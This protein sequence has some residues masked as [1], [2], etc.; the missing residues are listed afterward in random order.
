[1]MTRTSPETRLCGHFV[2]TEVDVC[3]ARKPP[4]ARACGGKFIGSDQIGPRWGL[5]GVT[6]VG[7]GASAAAGPVRGALPP[8][9]SPLVGPPHPEL[10]RWGFCT[11]LRLPRRGTPQPESGC[12]GLGRD[13]GVPAPRLRVARRRPGDCA[14]PRNTADRG[15][16][17]RGAG[18]AALCRRPSRPSRV[19]RP[20]APR[21]ES[22][23]A[24]AGP[25][26]AAPGCFNSS[27]LVRHG[28]GAVERA[29]D[30]RGRE[31]CPA[32]RALEPASTAKA[33]GCRQS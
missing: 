23:T 13:P 2:A 19:L 32:Q 26:T 14:A 15:A 9:S 29:G 31:K 30:A 28:A 7:C 25:V 27:R 11:A 22:G 17:Q 4:A 6:E 5:R 16:A 21:G 12:G 20:V 33:F 24:P 3:A 1:M 10:G 18:R 8:Y